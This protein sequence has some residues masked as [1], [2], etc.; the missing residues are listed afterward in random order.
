MRVKV[1][2]IGSAV[3]MIVLGCRGEGVYDGC[4]V[5]F[6]VCE[7]VDVSLCVDLY[8]GVDVF[9]GHGVVFYSMSRRMRTISNAN[10]DILNHLIIG[11]I[12]PS[13]DYKS[14]NRK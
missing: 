5:V 4:L 7:F 14:Y 13:F 6:Y 3:C 1:R 2:R 10:A 9:E 11:G 12:F 8:K